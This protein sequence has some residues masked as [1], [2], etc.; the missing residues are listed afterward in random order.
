MMSAYFRIINKCIATTAPHSIN[1]ESQIKK[2]T[3]SFRSTPF[4]TNTLT[5]TEIMKADKFRSAECT[6]NAITPSKTTPENPRPGMIYKRPLCT[7]DT[8]TFHVQPKLQISDGGVSGHLGSPQHD[9]RLLH[10]AVA[11]DVPAG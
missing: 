5:T 1:E 11:Q 6:S 4:Q 10:L 3:Y 2:V 8:R 9:S 7:S